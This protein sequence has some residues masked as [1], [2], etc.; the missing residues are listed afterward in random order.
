MIS[1]QRI[2]ISYRTPIISYHILLYHI[3]ED[4][5]TNTSTH[6]SI[7]QRNPVLV[8]SFPIT[9]YSYIHTL[10]TL[11]ASYVVMITWISWFPPPQ[12]WK[13]YDA[14]EV[15][16]VG[17]VTFAQPQQE[18]QLQYDPTTERQTEHMIR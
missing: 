17:M 15:V 7:I 4:F 13:A 8:A 12:D 11:M 1:Y 9:R 5:R 3:R 6:S 16:V 18:A 10:R 14:I 2:R